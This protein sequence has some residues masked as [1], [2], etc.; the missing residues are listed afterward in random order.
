MSF[1][2]NKN[3]LLA[4]FMLTQSATPLK[5]MARSI[6]SLKQQAM[7]LSPVIQVAL[8][9]SQK[10]TSLQPN[11]KMREY[12]QMSRKEAAAILGISEQASHHEI[13]A[14]HREL[15]KKFH[16]DI[17]PASGNIMRDCNTARD[18]L[19]EEMP[20]KK[21]SEQSTQ[22]PNK[23]VAILKKY[24]IPPLEKVM[25]FIARKSWQDW[26]DLEF[27]PFTTNRVLHQLQNDLKNV[28]RALNQKAMTLYIKNMQETYKETY[29]VVAFIIESI[30]QELRTEIR[31]S[32]NTRKAVLCDALKTFDA[33]LHQFDKDFVKQYDEGKK[34]IEEGKFSSFF[35]NYKSSNYNFYTTEFPKKIMVELWIKYQYEIGKSHTE[36]YKIITIVTLKELIKKYIRYLAIGAAAAASAYVAG[37]TIQNW[38][39]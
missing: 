11:F 38:D 32:T 29:G 5:S 10:S 7:R 1:S 24:T 8:Q 26:K 35:T 2:H 15:A 16:P 34:K 3:L 33:L 31:Q 22:K 6:N 28:P 17:N 20:F 14:R 39:N 18:V 9:A 23:T 4:L 21:T 27:D 30:S 37:K 36:L 13:T 12:S 25:A 19:L